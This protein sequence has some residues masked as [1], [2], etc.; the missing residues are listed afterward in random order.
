MVHNEI[1]I[2][3]YIYTRCRYK[4]LK[5][6]KEVVEM[7]RGED[8][9]SFF[10]SWIRNQALVIYTKGFIISRHCVFRD[11]HA[12]LLIIRSISCFNEIVKQNLIDC[13]SQIPSSSSCFWI[14]NHKCK[15]IALNHSGLWHILTSVV[16]NAFRQLSILNT[17]WKSQ[18]VSVML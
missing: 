10:L 2:K 8:A 6:Q 11:R 16:L 13:K 7:P 9:S 12:I 17:I 5:N 4:I 15:Q 14:D 3:K 18:P 1:E